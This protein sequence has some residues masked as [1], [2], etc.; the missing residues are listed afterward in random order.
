MR[1][2]V[3]AAISVQ[4][5]RSSRASAAPSTHADSS[6]STSVRSAARSTA[7][8]RREKTHTSE[9]RGGTIL[10]E[11]IEKLDDAEVTRLARVED[12]RR[13]ALS[14]VDERHLGE[15]MD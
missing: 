3:R 11:P 6:L 8:A 5:R 7:V 12:A 4:N 10:R 13:T 2:F 1:F 15:T 9:L 14:Y